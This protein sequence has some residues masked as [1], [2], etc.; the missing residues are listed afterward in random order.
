[1]AD[2]ISTAREWDDQL[3]LLPDVQ[4]GEHLQLI[5]L[6]SADSSHARLLSCSAAVSTMTKL[7]KP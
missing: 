7:G 2:S 3:Q 1:L 5:I 6:K 4:Q